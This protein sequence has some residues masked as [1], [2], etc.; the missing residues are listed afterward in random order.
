MERK[1]AN[2]PSLAPQFEREL[3]KRG[4][5]HLETYPALANIAIVKE[6]YTNA[7]TLGALPLMLTRLTIL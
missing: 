6:F 4:W 7:T 5:G 1:E 2:I 3:N